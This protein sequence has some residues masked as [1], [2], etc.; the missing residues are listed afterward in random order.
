ML[1]LGILQLSPGCGI[2]RCISQRWSCHSEPA[3]GCA[4]DTVL[5]HG[6]SSGDKAAELGGVWVLLPGGP[7]LCCDTENEAGANF[8]H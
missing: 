7:E 8:T 4:G 1:S 2:S 5:G 6:Q 3:A